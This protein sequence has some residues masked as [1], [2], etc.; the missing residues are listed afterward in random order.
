MDFPLEDVLITYWKW[1][2]FPFQPASHVV[3]C[4]FCWR[5]PGTVFYHDAKSWDS[6]MRRIGTG[7]V[8]SCCLGILA[9]L[10]TTLVFLFIA[11]CFVASVVVGYPIRWADDQWLEGE[12]TFRYGRK[13]QQLE[14]HVWKNH[15]V[16]HENNYSVLPSIFYDRSE[17]VYNEMIRH[18][19]AYNDCWW[20]WSDWHLEERHGFMHA[21]PQTMSSEMVFGPHEM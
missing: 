15:M 2:D 1:G 8:G 6:W 17:I 5:V 21:T 3:C 9:F 10:A 4:F 12:A 11:F 14:M 13:S 7:R 18:E 20:P 16:R 19:N